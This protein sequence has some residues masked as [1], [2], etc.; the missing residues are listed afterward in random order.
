MPVNVLERSVVAERATTSDERAVS[1]GPFRLLTDRRLLLEGEKP[2]RLGSRALD[3]LVALVEHPGEV[4][5]KNELIAR[6]WPNTI[7]EESN[8]KFQISALRRTLGGGNRY[9]LNVPGRGYCFIAPVTRT[10]QPKSVAP[11]ATA[12]EAGHNLPAHLTRL[13]GR[14]DTVSRLARQLAAQ[15]LLTIVGPGGIGKTSVALAVAEALITTYEHGVWLIDLAP[16]GDP[17]LVPTALADALGLEI[18]SEDPLPRLLD[19]LRDR[20]SL[21]VLDNCE[22]VIDAAAA[23]AVA[24]LRSAPKVQILATSREPL[25]I[26]GEHV[27]RLAALASP[28]ASLSLSAEEALRFPAAQLFAERAAAS[29]DEFELSDANAPI[30]ADICSKL[31]GI[32]LAIELAAARVHAFGVRGVAAR[33]E[34]RFQLLTRGRRTAL[35]RHRTLR[36][37]LDWSYDLLPEPER[38]VLR[39]VAVFAGGFTEEAASAVAA[40]AEIVASKIVESVANLVAKSLVMVDLGDVMVRYRL[41]ET[42]R[43]YALQKLRESGEYE[44]VARRHAEYHRDLFEQ[45]EGEAE[46]R[47]MAEWLALYRPRIDNLRAALD[48]AFSPIGDAS[49]GVAL[50]AA[51]VP[52][53][54]DL[55]MMAEC[56]RH[57]DRALAHFNSDAERNP[58]REMHLHAALGMSLNYTTGPVPETE[59]AW[60]KTLEI[61]TSLDDTEY[62]LRALRGLWAHR[63]NGGEYRA[64]LGL[65]DEFNS[66]AETTGDPADL[67][68]GDRMAGLMLHYLGDQARARGRLERIINR[69]VTPVPNSQTVRFL[70]D[71]QV[72]VR[73]LLSRI[74]WLQGFPDQATHTARL[75]V[76]EAK[77]TGHALSL[78]HALAQAA[79]PVALYTGDLAEAKRFVEVLLGH[80]RELGL[81]GW[82]ARG[83]CFQGT[84][85]IVRGDYMT[86]LPLLRDALDELRDAG[87]APGYSSFLGVLARGLGR[88]GR[89][90]EGLE[91]IDQALS[92]TKHREERWCRP[93]LLRT[94]GELHL[95]EGST[96]AAIAT[97][98][99]FRQALDWARRDGTL[100]W[101]LRAAFSLGRVWRGQGRVG[102]A[103]DLLSAVYGRFTEGFD[104]ADLKTAKALLDELL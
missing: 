82:I 46:A 79:C 76:D 88:A 56:R 104:T 89:V 33:L 80:A 20:R 77:A 34:D 48:W 68:F 41:P 100:S 23:L 16:Y 27:H 1:F 2:V 4:V 103:R 44:Q 101:E 42:I 86:G 7:V 81:A 61:A 32:A 47:P 90:S 69:P 13:I 54:V 3:I 53:W 78:C 85:L 71:Q 22:H 75:I 11:Q 30:V 5:G 92:L 9:L 45:A 28:P 19:V 43:A 24:V 95:L 50:T 60:T 21:L 10:E 39:R 29:L 96:D 63:M 98:D 14:A 83:R 38:A 66:L 25:R 65:A 62:Q 67:D 35:P 93:E 73:A 64:A 99:C 12:T 102:E 17:R 6:V 87:S 18:H 51:S 94:K 31:D 70:L 74:L 57:V 59:A 84:A 36:A 91:A 49:I 15:R 37:T 72:T 40:S 97:E 55:S 58:R 26:E 52:L 8:L